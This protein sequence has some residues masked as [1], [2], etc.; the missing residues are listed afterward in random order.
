MARPDALET[1]ITPQMVK[2]LESLL[3]AY[4]GAL[5]HIKDDLQPEFEKLAEEGRLSWPSAWASQEYN[6]SEAAW[7]LATWWH[8]VGSHEL[9]SEAKEAVAALKQQLANDRQKEGAKQ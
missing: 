5:E 2:T 4:Q 3:G 7:R 9:L 1:V 6:Q 8:G